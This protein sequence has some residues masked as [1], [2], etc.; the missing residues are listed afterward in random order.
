M[1]TWSRYWLFQ[2][3][4]WALTG[5]V[6]LVLRQWI[7][8]S[9]AVVFGLLALVVIKIFCFTPFFAA[10]TTHESRQESRSSL[11]LRASSSKILIRKAFCW[12]EVSYGK[13]G[14]NTTIGQRPRGL[15]YE[16]KPPME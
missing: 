4:G 15:K 13:L 1:T 5:V 10:P 9:L 2:I 16:S 6:L 11:G 8:I 3:P 12:F 14:F 7:D